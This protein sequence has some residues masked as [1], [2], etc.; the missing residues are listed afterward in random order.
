[1]FYSDGSYNVP[2]RAIRQS[3]RM[4]RS[5]K[6]SVGSR[7]FAIVKSTG[8]INIPLCTFQR[9]VQWWF[10]ALIFH[11]LC[12]SWALVT[13]V[14][15]LLTGV[16]TVLVITAGFYAY[17]NP[18]TYGNTTDCPRLTMYVRFI[19]ATSVRL[20]SSFCTSLQVHS[21]HCHLAHRLVR[22]SSTPDVVF[23]I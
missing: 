22:L 2:F 16:W 9:H 19:G 4:H 5:P 11:A 23:I 20:Q 10:L 14:M 17:S 12:S 6:D 21:D 7:R 3:M 8:A 18:V 13:A 15:Q 1:M